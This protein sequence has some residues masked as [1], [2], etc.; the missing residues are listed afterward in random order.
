MCNSV[1]FIYFLQHFANS[2]ITIS[3]PQ[4]DSGGPLMI[5][6]RE[7]RQVNIGI[8]SA[9]VGCG[10]ERLP[11]LYTRVSKYTNWI[12]DTIRG[13]QL[14]A[15]AGDHFGTCHKL[16]GT[17]GNCTI[18]LLWVFSWCYCINI[19]LLVK[20]LKCC[21]IVGE[22]IRLLWVTSAKVFIHRCRILFYKC[23]NKFSCLWSTFVY[24]LLYN[25]NVLS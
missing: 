18:A 15:W 2:L 24:K 4:G 6:D 22:C 5:K 20:E 10:R 1:Q 11:G 23:Y 7:G 12:R 25:T 8:V 13:A 16:D 17:S 21:I 9:G 14:R 3:V 19:K